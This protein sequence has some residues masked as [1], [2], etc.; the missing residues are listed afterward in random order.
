M[1]LVL[2]L[3]P[4]ID[5]LGRGFEAEGFSVVRGPDILFGGDIRSFHV[6][7]GRFGGV[8]GGPPCQEFSGL[9]RNPDLAAGRAMLD[10]FVR[11]VHEAKPDWFLMENVA[12]VPDVHV[13]GYQMQRFDLNARECGSDQSRNR[14]F[15]YGSATGCVLIPDRVT[16]QG[17][18][19]RRCCTASEG[20]R[21]ERRRWADFCELQ[22]LP[23]DFELPGWSIEAK[24]RAVGNGV[25]IEVARTIARAVKAALPMHFYESLCACGCGRLVDGKQMSATPACRKRLSRKRA[26]LSV[27]HLAFTTPGQSQQT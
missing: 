20:T 23:R 15:Q 5:M 3:F 17:T 19:V 26:R 1:D 10:E 16:N 11:V 24:Y 12:R 22:G 21:L 25:H 13:E 9:N 27:T 18:R 14:H 8:V 4:G 2:S 7:V 6:P